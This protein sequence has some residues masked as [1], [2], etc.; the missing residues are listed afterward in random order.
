M[1]A[2][3][4]LMATCWLW[5]FASV[6]VAEQLPVA[7]PVT[8]TDNAGP[9]PAAGANEAMPAQVDVTVNACV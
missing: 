7:S 1:P 9:E 8:V 5:L 4:T 3:E 6:T 2:V